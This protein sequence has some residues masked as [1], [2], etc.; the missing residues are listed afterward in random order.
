[1]RKMKALTVG[2][3]LALGVTAGS[4]SAA[5]GIYDWLLGPQLTPVVSAMVTPLDYGISPFDQPALTAQIRANLTNYY[6]NLPP[7]WVRFNPNAL[8]AGVYESQALFS[9]HAQNLFAPFPS[10]DPR[11]SIPYNYLYSNPLILCGGF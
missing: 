10:R 8:A 2:L 4:A 1:M 3:L 7:S 9:L 11:C 5:G 6:N